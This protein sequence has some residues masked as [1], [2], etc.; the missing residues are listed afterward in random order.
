MKAAKLSTSKR[1]QRVFNVLLDGKRHTTRDLIRKAHV[2]A[3]SAVISEI[4]QNGIK[5]NC[6]CKRQTWHYWLA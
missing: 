5:V 2:C 1:L 3:V 4:R 6:E